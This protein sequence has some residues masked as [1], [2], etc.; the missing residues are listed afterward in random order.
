MNDGLFEWA[1]KCLNSA[2]FIYLASC[3]FYVFSVATAKPAR[4]DRWARFGTWTVRLGFLLHTSGLLMRWYLGGISRPPWTNL[5]ESLVFFSWGVT[6]FQIYADSKWKLRLSGLI[7]M[8]LVFILMGMSVMTPNKQV[9]PLIPALQS[10]WLKIHVVFGMLS[11]A[12]FT[13]AGVIAFLQLMRS[14][15]SLSRIAAGISLLAVVNLGISGGSALKTGHFEM[16]KTRIAALPDGREVQTADTYRDYEGGPVLTR[17]EEV[18]HANVPYFV[19][20][21]GFAGAC[22]MFFATKR[23]G[24]GASAGLSAADAAER[25]FDLQKAPLALFLVGLVGMFGLFGVIGLGLK[26]SATLTLHSNPY[27]T[28]LLLMTFFFAVAFLAIA[29][30]YRAFLGLLPTS[31]RLDEMSYV[32]IL[33]AFPFQTLLLITGAIWAFYAW[34]RSW[35]WDPKETWAL[36]T[37]FAFLIYL[38]GRLLLRWKSTVLSMI[39]IV[40]F[41]IL[42]FAFLGVN[43]VLSGLHSYGAA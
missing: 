1:V 26:N 40:G 24:E 17:T 37:W 9:E 3:F 33:F 12:G 35:G 43:L 7:A 13:M 25:G 32:N 21:L 30:H 8:P 10:Y 11:Y 38:H 5:Y 16:A 2:A 4:A 23:R 27:L 31:E 20:L 41:V 19:S 36:I 29:R 39:A 15:V 34:G 42:V 28:I 14:G 6:L 18:P 22:V